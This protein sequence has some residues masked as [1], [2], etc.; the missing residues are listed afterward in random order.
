MSLLTY[1]RKE[2]EYLVEIGK[3]TP[4]DLKHYDVCAEI[5]KAEKTQSRLAFEF[6]YQE[7]K[8][9]RVINKKKCPECHFPMGHP[10]KNILK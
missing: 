3:K 2:L 10:R 7:T 6:K 9:I 4:A 5:A 8:S 1:T